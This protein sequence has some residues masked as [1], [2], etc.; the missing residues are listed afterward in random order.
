MTNLMLGINNYLTS[1]I[2]I[3]E[4]NKTNS[5]EFKEMLNLNR[6]LMFRLKYRTLIHTNNAM[7]G[8]HFNESLDRMANSII[9]LIKSINTE[10]SDIEDFR[11]KIKQFETVLSL[12]VKYIEYIY[13]LLPDKHLDELSKQMEEINSILGK[14]T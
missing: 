3:L 5:N 4:N 11:K 8:G 14:Y 12:L 13:N 7:I 2:Y 6:E 10:S 1:L 9:D